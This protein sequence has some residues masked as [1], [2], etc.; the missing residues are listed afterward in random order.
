MALILDLLQVMIRKTKKKKKTK[1]SRSEPRVSTWN[2]NKLSDVTTEELREAH[3][4]NDSRPRE[5]VTRESLQQHLP[6]VQ[7]V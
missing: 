3:H 7:G 2:R 6:Q 5:D 4:Q 1:I